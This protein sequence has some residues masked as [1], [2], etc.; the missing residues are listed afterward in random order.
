MQDL[1]ASLKLSPSPPVDSLVSVDKEKQ[2]KS[3]C[4]G[5]APLQITVLTSDLSL[6]CDTNQDSHKTGIVAFRDVVAPFF[7]DGSLSEIRIVVAKTGK[8]ALVGDAGK[9]H[10]LDP[11]SNDEDIEMRISSERHEH[12][13]A[14][15]RC[16][17]AMQAALV[18]CSIGVTTCTLSSVSITMIDHSLVGYKAL[19][20]QLL[21]DVVLGQRLRGRLQLELPE[22]LDGTQCSVTFDATYQTLPFAANAQETSGLWNDLQHLSQSK[23]QVTQIIPFASVDARLLYGVPITVCPGLE[24]NIGRSQEMELL[25]RSLFRV[26]RD[27]GIALLLTCEDDS[28][29]MADTGLFLGSPSANGFLLMAQE[30]HKSDEHMPPHTGLIFLYARADQLLQETTSC[31]ESP[32]VDTEMESQYANYIEQAMDYLE[33][34]SD[35]PLDPSWLEKDSASAA[36]RRLHKSVPRQ[37]RSVKGDRTFG[38]AHCEE[39][40]A[41]M[42]E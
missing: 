8:L 16:M 24:D 4:S 28:K 22:L 14:V 40:R 5:L 32:L 36:R 38:S 20:R 18:E 30:L 3:Q 9:Q 33:V 2:D 27:R 25:V 15:A 37:G 19:S 11:V 23:L 21:R 6:F 29:S 7:Q 39:G 1:R 42:E 35:N 13:Q 17:T 31:G 12:V 26:L 41:A 10:D 34:K